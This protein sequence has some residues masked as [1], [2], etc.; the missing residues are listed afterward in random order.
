MGVGVQGAEDAIAQIGA[1][2]SP[3]L[4][5]VIFE[6]LLELSPAELAEKSIDVC[7]S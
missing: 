3:W 5:F 7:L 1:L 6:P 2:F 4:D